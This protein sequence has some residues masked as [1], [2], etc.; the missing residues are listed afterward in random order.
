MRIMLS[1][2]RRR[3]RS[4]EEE[5]DMLSKRRKGLDGVGM[6]TE[7][8]FEAFQDELDGAVEIGTLIRKLSVVFSSVCAP[9]A[10]EFVVVKE[11]IH[12][13]DMKPIIPYTTSV[14]SPPKASIR[15]PPAPVYPTVAPS[16]PFSNFTSARLT[17]AIIVPPEEDM[18]T[19]AVDEGPREAVKEEEDFDDFDEEEWAGYGMAL[20]DLE[21]QWDAPEPDNPPPVLLDLTDENEILESSDVEENLLLEGM[22]SLSQRA[23]VLEPAK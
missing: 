19:F 2:T 10:L 4:S 17:Q 8:A 6:T 12:G 18:A 9:R 11:G 21:E 7:L 5:V 3:I 14:P 1:R 22:I 23:L 16:P 15:D 13:V 20:G